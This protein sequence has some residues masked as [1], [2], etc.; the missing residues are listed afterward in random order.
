MI[1]SILESGMETGMVVFK[2][3]AGYIEVL[4]EN[5]RVSSVH[6]RDYTQ[7]RVRIEQT[8][9]DPGNLWFDISLDEIDQLV[10]ALVCYNRE[11]R[12]LENMREGEENVNR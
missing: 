9:R 2:N 7:A 4:N 3:S 11:R 5:I 6:G 12:E 10:E 1:P 8:T